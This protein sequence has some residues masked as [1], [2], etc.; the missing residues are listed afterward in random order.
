MVGLV[1]R[2]LYKSAGNA[3]LTFKE[4]QEVLLDIEVS[5]NNRPLNYVE[6]DVDMPVLAP[7]SLLFTQPN[8]LPEMEL[9]QIERG[10]LRK[11]AKY[12]KRCKDA[13]WSRWTAEYVRGL[14]ERHRLKHSGK[15]NRI[16]IGDVVIIRDEERNR[17]K[18]KLGIVESLIEG[19]D[20]VIRAVK[21][22]AG[23]NRLERAVQQLYP[24]ELTFDGEE[25]NALNADAP[26]FRP[27]RDA[28]VAAKARI[29]DITQDEDER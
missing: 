11:R 18:W 21:L 25:H 26:V 17:N 2:A 12:L 23:K 15:K 27:K 22:R 10:E 4:L 8:Q 13:L 16:E 6:E 19:R 14:R 20:G 5:L 24:L 7:N 9:Y 1:K 29:L 28:A 3:L